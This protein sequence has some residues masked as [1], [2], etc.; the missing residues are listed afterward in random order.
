M[1]I[2]QDLDAIFNQIK[3]YL[4]TLDSVRE[5]I[6]QIQ[7]KTV[8]NCSEIIKKI[9]REE[10]DP[11]PELID[12]AR[13]QLQNM[14]ELIS[15]TPGELPK[16]YLQIVKQEFGEAIIL[17]HLLKTGN[18]PTIK[19][20]SIDPLD[21]A[22][23]LADVV[24]ELRRAILRCIR[25]ENMPRAKELLDY[26]DEIYTYLFTLDYPGGMIPGLRKKTDN[27]RRIL[28]NTEGE[29]SVSINMIKL[30]SEL[31]NHSRKLDQ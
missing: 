26:M 14:Q 22:Y 31:Q 12:E 8:R 13:S 30:K 1:S 16:N 17:Y 9:H 21:Y 11:I 4:D 25:S 28:A 19:T 3:G 2:N 18:L 27:A 6:L 24:G 15:N 23:A 20:C 29:V 10:W 7:R 5:N